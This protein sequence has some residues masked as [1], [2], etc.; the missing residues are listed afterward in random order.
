MTPL[1]LFVANAAAAG[2]AIEQV[3]ALPP[4]ITLLLYTYYFA[5]IHRID[6]RNFSIS[7]WR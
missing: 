1:L 4:H 5:F 3:F 7:K 6:L 2:G